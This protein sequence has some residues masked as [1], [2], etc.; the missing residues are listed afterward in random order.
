MSVID[1]GLIIDRPGI[2]L[3]LDLRKDWEMRTTSTQIRG[4]IALIRKGTGQIYGCADLVNVKG[5]LS[6]T[7]LVQ[8]VQHHQIPVHD[9]EAGEC[10]KRRYAW[11]LRNVRQL[12]TPVPYV[13]RP[14]AVI[15]VVLDQ[16]AQRQL[17]RA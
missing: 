15:W 9:I 13:H 1:R 16:R 14:G 4:T 2:E 10:D 6:R 12:I 3:I 11:I 17:S 8:A 5:P 7:E